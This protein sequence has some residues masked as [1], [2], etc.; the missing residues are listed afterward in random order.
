M[1]EPVQ[2]TDPME[3]VRWLSAGGKGFAFWLIAAQSHLTLQL[4][5]SLDGD[6]LRGPTWLPTYT[7]TD[8]ADAFLAFRGHTVLQFARP[9]PPAVSVRGKR[10]PTLSDHTQKPHPGQPIRTRS[11]RPSAQRR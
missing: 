8:V 9:R 1:A 7:L 4:L 3:E 2:S 6:R 11:Q 10:G 5:S